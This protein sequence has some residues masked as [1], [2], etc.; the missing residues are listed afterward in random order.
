MS[1]NQK[2]GNRSLFYSTFSYE[3]VA[4]YAFVCLSNLA[5]HLH[6]PG[7]KEG[8]WPI[9]KQDFSSYERMYELQ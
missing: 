6:N 2:K 1:F 4:S 7:I 5:F 3:T 9:K 8:S